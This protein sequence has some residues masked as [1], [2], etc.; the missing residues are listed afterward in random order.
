M[1]KEEFVAKAKLVHGGKYDYSK[2]NYVKTVVPVEIICPVHGSFFQKPKSHLHG[3]GCRACANSKLHITNDN[4]VKRAKEIHGNKYDYSQTNYTDSRI[5]VSIICKDCGTMF[6]QLPHNHLSGRGCPNCGYKKISVKVSKPKEQ[7]LLDCK[8]ILGDGYSYDKTKYIGSNE[9]VCITCK[10]HGDFWKFPQQVYNGSGCPVCKK[11]QR[12]EKN[13]NVFL[14]KAKEIHKNKYSYGNAIYVNSNTK[15]EVTCPKHGG[16]WVKPNA[17]LNGVGCRL[18]FEERRGKGKIIPYQDFIRDASIIH[19]NKYSYKLINYNTYIDTHHKVPIICPE[20]GVFLQT[21]HLH[22]SGGGCPH[23]P[24]STISIGE[25]R[26]SEVLKKYNIDFIPQ[27][28]FQNDNLFC[29]NRYFVVDFYLQKYNT[30]IEYNGQQHFH[31]SG[32]FGGDEKLKR[33]QDRDWSLRLYC[34]EHKIKLVEIPYTELKNIETILKNELR[35]K[36]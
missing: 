32:Y 9:K 31:R 12:Q 22:K 28:R 8:R 6:W 5:K 3:N 18:C 4:F 29:R 35:I 13:K 26:V 36:K 30:V 23:C 25:Q 21:P 19:K 27:F 24:P 34:K 15:I 17:H 1:T 10:S 16:F 33:T 2:V 11:E 7:F 20:H 14:K